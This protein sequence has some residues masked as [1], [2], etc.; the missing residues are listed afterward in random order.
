MKP[1]IHQKVEKECWEER[2]KQ[3]VQF[4]KAPNI[5]FK[6]T[7]DQTLMH[8]AKLTDLSLGRMDVTCNVPPVNGK[9]FILIRVQ[10]SVLNSVGEAQGESEC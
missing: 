1:T 10:I 4:A 3:R 9:R 6:I 8:P 2:S 7:L 5:C